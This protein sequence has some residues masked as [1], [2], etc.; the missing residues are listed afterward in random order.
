MPRFAAIDVGSNA[1]RLMIVEADRPDRLKTLFARRVPVRM[2]H[3]VFQTGRLDAKT[4]DQSVRTLSDF[5]EILEEFEVD[6]YRAVVTASA[7]DADDREPFLARVRAE[8]GLRL[9]P[10]DGIEEARLVRLAVSSAV[11]LEGKNAL[12]MDLGGGSLELSE[13]DNGETGWS[14]SLEIGTV[15]LLEAFLDLRKP[16]KPDQER[17]LLEYIE[18]MLSQVTVNLVGPGKAPPHGPVRRDRFDMVVGTGGNFEAI[19]ELASS[20]PKVIDSARAGALLTQASRMSPME[21]MRRYKLKAD[22]A[23]VIVPALYVL[24]AVTDRTRAREVIAP[25]VGLKDGILL[26]LIEKSFRVWD[27]RGEED[28]IVRASIQLGRRYHFDE[29]HSEQVDRLATA[30]FDATASIHKLGSEDRNL[31]RVAA[32]LHDVGDFVHY[33]SHHKHTQYVIEHSDIMGLNANSR[34][35]AGCIA[36]YHRRAVPTA[37]H[38]SYSKLHPMEKTRVRKLS[39]ILRV[40]DAL[41]REHRGKV[42]DI[43]VIVEPKRV[44][45]RV[46]GKE[47]LSLETWTMVRKAE[48]FETLFRR[49][50]QIIERNK[51]RVTPKAER[52]TKAARPKKKPQKTKRPKKTLKAIKKGAKRAVAKKRKR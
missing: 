35:I 50:I 51:T 25:G 38:A 41:D 47:D 24:R 14:V 9:E 22:R 17:L 1:S 19:A 2:G 46:Q 3:G 48:P 6:H 33:A 45:L 26:E 12:L 37:K 34:M 30:L 42:G 15:R 29:P 23:D 40:A 44:V 28:A 11:R 8:S 43:S 27:Y 49:K 13:L 31:L 39:A 21:R 4:V 36:R 52:P 10:I 18:R 16:V 32:L 5:A 7:R 20:R